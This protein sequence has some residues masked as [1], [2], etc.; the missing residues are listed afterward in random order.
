MLYSTSLYVALAG[1]DLTRHKER[2]ST[3]QVKEILLEELKKIKEEGDN[4][5]KKELDLKVLQFSRIVV[6]YEQSIKKP[7]DLGHLLNNVTLDHADKFDDIEYKKT[8]EEVLK[9]YRI[10]N[11][12]LKKKLT[13]IIETAKL[14]KP[15]KPGGDH[16]HLIQQLRLKDQNFDKILKKI[17]SVTAPKLLGSSPQKW[18]A[19]KIRLWMPDNKS[20]G[21]V[22]MVIEDGEIVSLPGG[23]YISLWPEDNTSSVGKLTSGV[24]GVNHTYMEDLIAEGHPETLKFTFLTLDVKSM[25]EGYRRLTE[26]KWHAF[27]ADLTVAKSSKGLSNCGSIVAALLVLG[28]VRELFPEKERSKVLPATPTKE[29]LW[30]M[31]ADEDPKSLSCLKK[32]K[33]KEKATHYQYKTWGLEEPVGYVG[34]KMLKLLSIVRPQGIP[35]KLVEHLR[36]AVELDEKKCGYHALVEFHKKEKLRRNEVEE[37]LKIFAGKNVPQI[38]ADY[39]VILLKLTRKV[40]S[41]KVRTMHLVGEALHLHLSHELTQL[42]LLHGNLTQVFKK[43]KDIYETIVSECLQEPKKIKMIAEINQEFFKEFEGILI[44][45]CE[46]VEA[47]AAKKVIHFSNTSLHEETFAKIKQSRSINQK[48]FYAPKKVKPSRGDDDYVKEESSEEEDIYGL[49]QENFIDDVLQSVEEQTTQV[50]LASVNLKPIPIRMPSQNPVSTN[51]SPKQ[52]PP[53][54]SLNELN[55]S[56][57]KPVLLNNPPVNVKPVG[58]KP[59]PPRSNIQPAGSI[60]STNT[61]SKV[62]NLRSMFENLSD[63]GSQNIKKQIPV[64]N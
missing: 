58:Q 27:G 20:V 18:Q 35:S 5:K 38:L 45:T 21:H 6:L 64:R 19:V 22:S 42:I 36:G 13:V 61:V 56:R 54:V 57:L 16:Q 26:L 30:E 2:K 52:Q 55:P 50:P 11:S 29:K 7:S 25:V 15:L 32:D 40:N 60:P 51:G 39:E 8:L 10:D 48:L 59:F 33:G 23:L 4:D 24:P 1:Y 34:E 63:G 44:K 37:Q 9:I 17:E 14:I 47:K 46:Q 12:K 62:Q 3:K 43:I 28:G 41:T 49:D 31:L 53:Q